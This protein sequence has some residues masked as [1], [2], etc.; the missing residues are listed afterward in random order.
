VIL[1]TACYRSGDMKKQRV[2][3]GVNVFTFGEVAKSM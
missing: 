1:G 2:E 3:V